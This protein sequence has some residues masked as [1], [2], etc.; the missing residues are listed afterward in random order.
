MANGVRADVEAIGEVSLELASGFT[1]LLRDILF[2]PSLQRNLISVSCLDDDDYACHFGDEKWHIYC[3]NDCVGVSL[4]QQDLYLLSL[5]ETMNSVCDAI[6][7]TSLSE[8]ANK[9]RKRTQDASSKLWH[10]RLG[11]ILRERIERFVKNGILPPLEFSKL[12]Q[13]IDC[14]KGKYA[15]KIKKN[16]KRSTGILQVIHTDIC[17]LFPVKS[18]DGYDSF[19]TFTD[20]YSRFGYIYPIKERTEALDKFKIFKAEVENQHNLKIK[21]VRSDRG[22]EYC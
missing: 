4:Q 16:A 22:G 13:C 11:H 8:N 20:N 14:I 3:N 6:E 1:L 2:V 10:Y 15:K 21:I 17:G 5:H 19:I 12:K 18:M 9:K 7:N